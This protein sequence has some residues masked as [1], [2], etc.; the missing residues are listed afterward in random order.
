MSVSFSIDV[1]YK[2]INSYIKSYTK[3]FSYNNVCI[4]LYAYKKV[5]ILVF[6]FLSLYTFYFSVMEYSKLI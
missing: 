4:Y 1:E 5:N 6:S 3:K 2:S